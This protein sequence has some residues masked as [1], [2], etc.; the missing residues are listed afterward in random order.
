MNIRSLLIAL[1]CCA[2]PH[3]ASAQVGDEDPLLVATKIA[4]PFVMQGPNGPEGLAIELWERVAA[5]LGVSYTYQVTELDELLDGVAEGRFDVGVGAISVTPE[6]EQRLDMS[7]GFF[8]DGLSIAVPAGSGRGGWLKVLS[9]LFTPAFISAVGALAVL[10]LVV[11]VLMWF[12]ER[13]RN[14]EE[15]NPAPGKGVGDGF[16]FAA[17]TMTTVGYGDKAPRTL[18]GRLLALVWMFASIIVISAFTGSIASSLTAAQID[19]GVRSP[20]DLRSAR[21]GAL[22]GSATIEALRERSVTPRR[23]PSLNEGLDALAKRNIDAFVHDG[24]ILTYRVNTQH[25]GELRMLEVR[26]DIGSYAIALPTGSALREPVNRAI[27][28]IT[29]S[30]QWKEDVKDTFAG[31]R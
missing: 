29:R 16:W 3:N 31:I 25:P 2:L 17:V 28:E 14:H 23:Y 6:R 9:N 7:H 1:L 12:L 24:S 26:F 22:D 4:E 27:L 10:L 30:P 5:E 18:P 21:V 8:T 11:G 15:F 13:R 20:E 19:S